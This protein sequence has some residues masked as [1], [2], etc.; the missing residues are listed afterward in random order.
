MQTN[1][2]SFLAMLMLLAEGAVAICPPNLGNICQVVYEG[3]PTL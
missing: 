3:V 2:Y 1:I